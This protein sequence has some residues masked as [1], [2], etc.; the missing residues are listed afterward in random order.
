MILVLK[1]AVPSLKPASYKF[2]ANYVNIGIKYIGLYKMFQFLY[3]PSQFTRYST[4]LH[5]SVQLAI[6]YA[7]VRRFKCYVTAFIFFQ[8]TRIF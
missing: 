7:T 8:L 5:C 2:L 6:L 3:P 1:H 4:C